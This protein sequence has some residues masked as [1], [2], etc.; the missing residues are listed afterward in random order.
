VD[1]GFSF[2]FYVIVKFIAYAAWCYAGLRWLRQRDSFRAGLGFGF[3]RLL[4][5]V[6]FGV[7]I[8]VVGGMMHLEVP[9]H[10]VLM[11]LSIYAPIRYLEWSILFILLIT[12][13]Q[14]VPS[15]PALWKRQAWILGGIVVSHLADLPLILT[16]YDGAK[17]FLPVGRFLC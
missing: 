3:L 6:F 5:G 7:G 16:S 14:A 13:L 8:F 2:F 10:P 12:R 1:S 11:Y 4:L 15:P 17:G 9:T